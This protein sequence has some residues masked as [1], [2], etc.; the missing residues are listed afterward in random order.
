MEFDTCLTWQEAV[1]EIHT[2]G[3]WHSQY[4][5]DGSNDVA[6]VNARGLYLVRKRL[7]P[8]RPYVLRLRA[9]S[10]VAYALFDQMLAPGIVTPCVYAPDGQAIWRSWIEGQ[11]GIAWREGLHSAFNG[12][13]EKAD[14][15]IMRRMQTSGSAKRIAL[16]DMIFLVQD[17]SASNWLYG[18]NGRFY[19]IDNSILWPVNG[20]HVD[21][22]VIK[23]FETTH[24]G[25]P[26]CN[27][28]MHPKPVE[29]KGGLFSALYAGQDLGNL[30]SSLNAF[31]WASYFDRLSETAKR[32]SYTPEIIRDW[33]FNAIKRRAEWIVNHDRLPTYDEVRTGEWDQFI[34]PE[35]GAMTV[36]YRG[37][38]Q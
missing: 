17:R 28:L 1:K 37:L 7:S 38:E 2:S 13:L 35:P 27:V 22:R 23:T 8:E 19:A 26:I 10:E 34:F 24:L 21:K 36:W 5:L 11:T 14:L 4:E 32:L 3:H 29:F 16:I 33:R 31:P 12:D 6:C 18:E 15:N 25:H 20:K 30:T 9:L